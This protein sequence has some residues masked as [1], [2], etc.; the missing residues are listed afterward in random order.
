MKINII[1]IILTAIMFVISNI[2]YH[3]IFILLF[4]F[5]IV[6]LLEFMCMCFS[7]NF[8]Y[9]VLY[10]LFFFALFFDFTYLNRIGYLSFILLIPVTVYFLFKQYL[11]EDIVYFMFLF[12]IILFNFLL[13]LYFYGNLDIFRLFLQIDFFSIFVSLYVVAFSLLIYWLYKQ[14]LSFGRL[15]IDI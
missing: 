5:N 10:Y 15:K 4:L 7:D 9:F 2:G 6:L 11:K 12:L 1:L 3:L 8:S 14:Q 13:I